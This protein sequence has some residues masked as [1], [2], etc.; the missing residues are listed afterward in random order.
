ML[1]YSSFDRE[2]REK[3][4]YVGLE[5]KDPEMRENKFKKNEYKL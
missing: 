1:C 3:M 4:R 2:K 5:L